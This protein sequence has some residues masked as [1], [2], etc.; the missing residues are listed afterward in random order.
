MTCFPDASKPQP[1]PQPQPYRSPP[2][3][4]AHYA[5]RLGLAPRSPDPVLSPRAPRVLS[6]VVAG[7]RAEASL[8]PVWWHE[9]ALALAST[10]EPETGQAGVFLSLHFVG[11]EVAAASALSQEA[12]SG[13]LPVSVRWSRHRGTLCD[14]L[15]NASGALGGASGGA[16]LHDLLWLSNPGLGHPFLAQAWAPSL[17]R[18]LGN[19]NGDGNSYGEEAGAGPRRGLGCPVLVTSHS[20]T[21]QGRDVA[22]IAELVGLPPLAGSEARAPIGDRAGG[23]A[24]VA[25]LRW[26]VAPEAARFRSLRA[27]ADPIEGGSVH[28][29]W[30]ALVVA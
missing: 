28:A 30:G 3:Q 17:R 25:G 27:V 12:A 29:N 18:L 6:V 19:G 5:L 24:G 9:A 16:S 11:P 2:P 20:R 21:D 10:A 23:V 14:F 7:A 15:D 26:A 13:D 22:A 4:V 8:P 1:Q